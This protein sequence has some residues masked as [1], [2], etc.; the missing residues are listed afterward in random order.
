MVKNFNLY[1]LINSNSTVRVTLWDNQASDFRRQYQQA[2]N[3]CFVIVF[4]CLNPKMFAGSVA[5]VELYDF[6]NYV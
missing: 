6:K 1:T 3:D 4:T 5:I 2:G